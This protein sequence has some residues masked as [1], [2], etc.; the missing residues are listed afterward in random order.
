MALPATIPEAESAAPPRVNGNTETQ[1]SQCQLLAQNP[2]APNTV[3]QRSTPA[4]LQ[5]TTLSPLTTNVENVQAFELRQGAP[6]KA[7]NPG[8][9]HSL[10][11][12]TDPVSDVDFRRLAKG[13]RFL[14]VFNGP[15]RPAD[16]LEYWAS[17][18]D[19]IVDCIDPVI[20]GDRHDLTDALIWEPLLEKIETGYYDGG[21]GGGA[22]CS[23][24]SAGRKND[25][26]PRA[27]RTETPPGLFGIPFFDARRNK[28]RSGSE[29]SWRYG[30]QNSGTFA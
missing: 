24:F 15:L 18:Y 16:G 25:G 20:A 6:L 21:A 11:G 10:P 2:V 5:V 22:P 23:T 12:H 7:I 1:P 3:G 28:S 27:L 14:S 29:L 9:K 13:L 4:P 26:G 8:K 19:A 30:K 17:Q